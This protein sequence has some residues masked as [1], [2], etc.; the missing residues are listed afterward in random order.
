MLGMG[1]GRI[2]EEDNNMFSNIL[3]YGSSGC[4]NA[5]AVMQAPEVFYVAVKE[6]ALCMFFQISWLFLQILVWSE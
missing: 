4:E 3:F 2:A 5:E 6:T 1:Q